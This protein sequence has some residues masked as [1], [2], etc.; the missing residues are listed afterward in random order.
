MSGYRN[1]LGVLLDHGDPEKN[2]KG[3]VF[4]F[5]TLGLDKKPVFH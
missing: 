3:S 1:L 4:K 5:L 2:R